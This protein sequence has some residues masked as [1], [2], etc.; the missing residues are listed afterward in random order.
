MD[1]LTTYSACLNPT[2]AE[3]HLIYKSVILENKLHIYVTGSSECDAPETITL[4][5]VCVDAN[6]FYFKDGIMEEKP[7]MSK[8]ALWYRPA[9]GAVAPTVRACFH[10]RH[11]S[12][13]DSK[14]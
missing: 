10:S 6:G 13:A 5:C 12:R 11:V 9:G 7:E 3:T 8:E 14:F 4:I 1:I 2:K